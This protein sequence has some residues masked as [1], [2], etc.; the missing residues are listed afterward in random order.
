[1]AAR[2]LDA[3]HG[4]ANGWLENLQDG[5][6]ASRTTCRV[7]GWTSTASSSAAATSSPLP[8]RAVV[9][10]VD[11]EDG[12]ALGR[13]RGCRATTRAAP[14][15][16]GSMARRGPARNPPGGARCAGPPARLRRRRCW[17]ARATRSRH[18]PV[19]VAV[20]R[21]SN[22][23]SGKPRKHGMSE[24]EEAPRAA[25]GVCALSLYLGAVGPGRVGLWGLSRPGA[26]AVSSA[27]HR[28]RHPPRR[29][30]D[31]LAVYLEHY[32]RIRVAADDGLEMSSG[33]VEHLT[34]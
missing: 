8:G 9:E 23:P 32:G 18:Y 30:G 14:S 2:L 19:S 12:A 7:D 25:S 3:T 34:P 17:R 11:D 29:L 1:M 20:Y 16:R 15:C 26:T 6:S 13:E 22:P 4:F 31:T 28:P 27:A 21:R 33:R 5:A 10:A 24:E